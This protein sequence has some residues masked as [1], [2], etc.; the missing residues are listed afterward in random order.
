MNKKKVL[1]VTDYF[2]PHWTGIVTSLT[3]LIEQ[4]SDIYEFDVLTVNHTNK[5][6]KNEKVG[7]A[8]VTRVPYQLSISRAKISFTLS[9]KYIQML[10]NSD[11]IFINSPHT[12]ILLHT[13]LARFFG[14][15]VVI[16]HQADL[17]LPNGNL[18]WFIERL[19]DIQTHC[20]C[21]LSHAVATYTDD[22]AH[23]SRILSHYLE[24]LTTFLLIPKIKKVISPPLP[25]IATQKKLNKTLFGFAGRYVEEKGID[26]LMK[27]I[28]KVVKKTKD[29]HFFFAGDITQY[30]KHD[31]FEEFIDIKHYITNLGL[32]SSNNMNIFMKNID[33][34][35]L[36]SRSECFGLVQIESFLA[37]KPVIVSD[38]PGA[39][40]PVL[41]TKY[42]YIFESENDEELAKK[43]ILF[44]QQK[45]SLSQYK[46]NVHSLLT[47][48]SYDSKIRTFIG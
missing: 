31:Y 30:E 20:A 48:S 11:T 18:N 27:A 13:L 38:I 8:H 10:Q 12:T 35:I 44:I 41:S 23:H 45:G 6:Q 43:I 46:N 42:G 1:I 22:Y 7:N 19:Y 14:K 34:L 36:P 29:V 4:Y 9:L 5:L 2:V 26:I 24:K 17:I 21:S 16:F 28:R 39:R 15:R 3:C 37:G 40:F 33:V 32:L 25:Q 47:Q